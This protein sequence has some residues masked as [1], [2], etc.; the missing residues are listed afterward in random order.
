MLCD[1]DYVKKI[2]ENDSI[3]NYY[4]RITNKLGVL[5]SEKLVF[6]K[7]IDFNHKI[8]DVGCGAGRTTI[9]LKKLGY[10]NIIGIDISENMIVKAR[11]ND[12]SLQFITAN[13]LNLPFNDKTFDVAFFSFNGLM[14][15]PD[16]VNREKAMIEIKRVL[17]NEGL[18]IFST[19]YLDNKLEKT[20]WKERLNGVIL[21]NFDIK[22]GDLFIDDMGVE[23][24]Y[25]HIPFIQE[26]R[27]MLKKTGYSI[28]EYKPR[29]DIYIESEEIENELDD[30]LYWIVRSN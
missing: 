18:F 19:P 24:I 26:V 14:L 22:L 5:I 29:T 20:F 6:E 11:R 28:L 27:D 3:V 15:I 12:P 9:G 23:N 21:D 17:K 1:T 25:I 2:Y 8:L 4:N 10:N 7:Y 13:V 16:I 30:N